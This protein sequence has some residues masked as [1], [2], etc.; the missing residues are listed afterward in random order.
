MGTGPGRRCDPLTFAPPADRAEQIA[1]NVNTSPAIICTLVSAL[2]R[3]GTGMLERTGW[4]ARRAVAMRQA[5]HRA[6]E[7]LFVVRV[8]LLR[9]LRYRQRAGKEH[10]RYFSRRLR[11]NKLFRTNAGFHSSVLESRSKL[12]NPQ[13]NR[14]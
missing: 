9:S 6:R 12:T 13:S 14:S 11:D 2:R 7:A 10:N 3:H 5:Q 1:Q 4:E 8:T